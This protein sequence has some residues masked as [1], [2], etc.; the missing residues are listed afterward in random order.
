MGDAVS[1]A[2]ENDNWIHRIS[3]F[4]GRKILI[5]GNHDVGI[6][7]EVFAEY[8]ERVLPDGGGMEMTIG[9]VECWLTHYPTRSRSDKF[10]IVG[11]IH[12]RWHIQKN[13]INVGVDV[14]HF[15]PYSED[16]VP[17]YLKAI[18]TYYDDDVWC[19]DH[20]ANK[21]HMDRGKKGS[22]FK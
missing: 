4:N 1:K 9:G 13:M 19:A 10:N 5:R 15:R 21:P 2:R 18:K 8:F 12:G 20:H 14:N 11:H 7:D 3:D 16:S 6:S 22:Y 17:Y